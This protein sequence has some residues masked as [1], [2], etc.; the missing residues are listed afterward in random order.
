VWVGALALPGVAWAARWAGGFR[1]EPARAD[2]VCRPGMLVL[3]GACICFAGFLPIMA[4][5]VYDPDPRTRYWPCVGL[6]LLVAGVGARLSRSAP[7]GVAGR[8]VMAA[9]LLGVLLGGAT[10]LVG[11]QSAFRDRWRLDQEQGRE[12]VRLLPDAPPLTFFVPLD[13]ASKGIRTGAPVFDAH[14]R[15]VWEF[16]W[17]APRFILTAFGRADVRSGFWRSW[18]PGAPVRGADETGIHF[19]DRLG[20]AFP[21]IEGSGSRV[22]WE[23]AVPFIIDGDA[24]VR[25]VTKVIIP[26][27]DGGEVTIEVPQARERRLPEVVFRLPR[28]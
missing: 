11:V 20:P 28:A 15:S 13:I 22:P 10:C 1:D 27:A 25:L 23:R 6:A 7:A 5:A 21:R 14:F 18:T 9:V 26:G 17:T 4:M 24:R 3:A 2:G 8:R 16:P 19:T 12:L